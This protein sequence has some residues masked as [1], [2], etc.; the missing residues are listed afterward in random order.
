M[1]EIKFRIAMAFNKNKTL[2]TGN[3]GL[4]FKDENRKGLNVELSFL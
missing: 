3:N 1:R 2:F 4:K